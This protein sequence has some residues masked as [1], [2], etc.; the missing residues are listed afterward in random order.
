[1]LRKL[2]IILL[3]GWVSITYAQEPAAIEEQGIDEEVCETCPLPEEEWTPIAKALLA[4]MLVGE[5]GWLP[6]YRRKT[7]GGRRIASCIDGEPCYPNRDWKL[8]PWVVYY[9]WQ[10][11]KKRWNGLTYAAT[12]RLYSAAM[13]PGLTSAKYERFARI[14]G[15]GKELQQIPRRRFL[16]RIAWDGSNLLPLVEKYDRRGG[17][18][19]FVDGWR[20]VREAVE[21][22]GNGEIENECEEARHWDGPGMTLPTRSLIKINCGE[23][24][25][26][27]FTTR[28]ARR[29]LRRERASGSQAD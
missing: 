26:D 7:K 29:Q 27:Y 22:W 8:Q 4:R 2:T 18:R 1:M 6:E 19:H 16:Q 10:D 12:I 25:N 23:T 3:L 11:M 9:R 5:S 17:G 21:S 20:A 15:M 28:A 13:K 14:H 24:L